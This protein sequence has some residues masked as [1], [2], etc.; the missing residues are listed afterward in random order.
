MH[1]SSI[2]K[3][4]LAMLGLAVA[5]GAAGCGTEKS[6]NPLSPN[7]AGPMAG[8][9]ITSPKPLQPVNNQEIVTGTP[10][11]LL[12]ENPSS[13]SE[14][15][16]W[17]NIELALDAEF[18]QRVHVA[19]RVAPGPNGR[20]AYRVSANLVSE[21]FYYWRARALDGANTGPYSG[22]ATFRVVTPVRIEPVIPVSPINGDP[23]TTTTPDL[24]V[25][26]GPVSGPAGPV[27]YRF[28]IA[29][30]HN[31]GNV[32]ALYDAARSDGGSTGVR[33]S[34]PLAQNTV[35]FW[36]VLGSDGTHVSDYS[37]IQSF[38][39]P[40]PVAPPP[41]PP[42]PNPPPPGPNPP[43]PNPPPGNPGSPRK[44]SPQEALNIIRSV[45]DA[46]GWNLG[47]S[48]SREQR[49]QFFWQAVATVHYGHP[50]FNPQGGDAD[51]CVKDA[52]GGRPPSDDV[53][54]S[55]STREAWDLIGSAG[56]NN[57]SFHLDFIGRLDSAQNVYPP[58]SSSLPR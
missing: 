32:V 53:L 47:S 21:R 42:G 43:N 58:P 6:R 14:R 50:R 5:V 39:T 38:R 49:I 1:V 3:P 57:Y 28:I 9:T 31:F 35:Y 2:P 25:T 52:G 33:V 11:E 16:H 54:V 41:P 55:C 8:V 40:A 19:E 7:V 4:W 26:N 46:L 44:I 17:L 15:P 23:I 27:I 10:I 45:H 48:S 36:R 24:V 37:A 12:M 56:A 30:D 29:S 34:T 51:W 18:Q 20:T 22:N 13:N